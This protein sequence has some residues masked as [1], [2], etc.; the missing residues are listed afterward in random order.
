M[1]YRYLLI[2]EASLELNALWKIRFRR[3]G[4]RRGLWDRS[5]LW[6]SPGLFVGWD[7]TIYAG[8]YPLMVGFNSIPKVAVPILVIWFGSGWIPA[9]LTAL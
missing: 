1:S 4:Q 8:L 7:R 9:V 6:S 5:C 2:V 3:F